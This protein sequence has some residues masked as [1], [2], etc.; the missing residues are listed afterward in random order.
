MMMILKKLKTARNALVSRGP[1]EV[2]K[3]LGM[4]IEQY[5]MRY[6]RLI[7]SK[8]RRGAR[9]IGIAQ[10]RNSDGCIKILYVT[11]R[12]EVEHGQTVRYRIY[13]LRKALSNRVQ[14]RFEIIENGVFKD[15]RCVGWADIV[16][17]MRTQWTSEVDTL[18]R[19]AKRAGV[20]VV[21]DIDDILFL[22][23]YVDKFCSILQVDFEKNKEIYKNIFSQ[24]GQTFHA[25]DFATT[26]TVFI[27]DK[28]K[29]NG[30]KAFV[31]HNGLSSKQIAISESLNK[32][33]EKKI[34]YIGYLSGTYTHNQDF[35]VALPALEKILEEYEDVCLRI[36]GYLDMSLLK[37]S[38]A[39]KTETLTFIKW[40]KL[41][42]VC[43][44]NFVNIAPLDTSNPFCHAKSELKYFEAAI[45][46]VPT[47]ASSTDTF[48]RCITHG[49]NGMLASSTDEWYTCIKAL[50]DDRQLYKNIQKNAYEQAVESYSPQAVAKEALIAYQGILREYKS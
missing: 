49:V 34:R 32:N 29:E 40:D 44:E 21:F 36:V 23:D 8:L 18:V 1:G 10:P 19:I 41:L 45:V 13:N 4:N 2:F 43:A 12:L 50:L 15:A 11:N 16:I 20:P 5:S 17:L 27:A 38:M 3:L 37:P 39:L 22:Q 48:K 7:G 35:L 30:K 26:S 33:T 6:I 31:I 25:A 42:K 46:G 9:L 24:Y 28:M 14:T 47:V